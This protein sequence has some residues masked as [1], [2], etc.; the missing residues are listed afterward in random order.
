MLNTNTKE[1]IP[2]FQFFK[3]GIN[4]K[5]TAGFSELDWALWGKT[6]ENLALSHPHILSLPGIWDI[7]F[8]DIHGRD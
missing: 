3:K 7:I 2:L 5:V 8:L 6:V 4:Y 1:A